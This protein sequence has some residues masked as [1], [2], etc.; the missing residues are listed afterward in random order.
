[1]HN[2]NQTIAIKI[3]KNNINNV[4]AV[5]RLT[6]KIKIFIYTDKNYI[7]ASLFYIYYYLIKFILGKILYQSCL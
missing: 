1:M 2:I 5:V 6:K 3:T 4:T 7:R